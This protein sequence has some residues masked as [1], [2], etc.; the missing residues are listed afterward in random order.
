MPIKFKATCDKVIALLPAVDESE[1]VVGSIIVPAATR[2]A[3]DNRNPI[4]EL[5]VH[6][7]GADVKTV[8]PGDRILYNKHQCEPVPYGDVQI[9][10]ILESQIFAILDDS[11]DPAPAHD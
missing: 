5:I 1:E 3:L 8:R 6:S 9:I 4:R 2:R 7:V 11:S 10:S